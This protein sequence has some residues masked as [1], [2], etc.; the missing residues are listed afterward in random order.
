MD[1][2]HDGMIVGESR[3]ECRGNWISVQ[4]KSFYNFIKMEG[5]QRF[6]RTRQGDGILMAIASIFMAGRYN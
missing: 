6:V 5:G 3:P 4:R 2:P 1:V